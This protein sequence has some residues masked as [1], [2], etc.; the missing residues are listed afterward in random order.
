MLQS[1]NKDKNRTSWLR[2]KKLTAQNG[3]KT[4]KMERIRMETKTERTRM[5]TKVEET[6]TEGIRME[7]KMVETRMENK[8]VETKMEIKTE[9]ISGTRTTNKERT[10]EEMATSQT[11]KLKRDT[12]T[13]SLLP[14]LTIKTWI[15]STLNL[16]IDM[17]NSK[18]T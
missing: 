7:T 13:T 4:N 18:T 8:M 6:K 5:E 3:I 9:R 17:T 16:K 12:A 1:V 15:Q 2:V 11:R 14:S 10:T